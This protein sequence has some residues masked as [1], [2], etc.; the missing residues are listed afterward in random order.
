MWSELTPCMYPPIEGGDLA[1]NKSR[2]RSVGRS[3]SSTLLC[4]DRW[5]KT[6]ELAKTL[7][8]TLG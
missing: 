1:Q 3:T 2:Q 5:V 8:Y 7:S 4:F 6:R